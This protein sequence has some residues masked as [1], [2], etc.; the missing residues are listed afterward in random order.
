MDGVETARDLARTLRK[1]LNDDKI[2][3]SFDEWNAWYAW[4]RSDSVCDGMFAAAMLHMFIQEAEKTGIDI[5]C[6][7]EAVNEGAILV[8]STSAKLTSM[9]KMFTVMKKHAMGKLLYCTNDVV[10][11]ELEG[12]ISVSLINTAYKEEKVYRI[13]MCGE[14]LEAELYE[15]DQI[16]PHSAFEKKDIACQAKEGYYEIIMPP[17]SVALL[18]QKK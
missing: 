3:I 18:R 11:T 17:H 4:Y 7:F 1:D 2:R 15:A 13:P 12:I 9:G 6:H 10:A 8:E 5:V 16:L 14:I